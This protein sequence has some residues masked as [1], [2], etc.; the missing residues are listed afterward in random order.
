MRCSFFA[1]KKGLY[2]PSFAKKEVTLDCLMRAIKGHFCS[3]L[4]SNIF[5]NPLF[6]NLPFVKHTAH[7]THLFLLS[8]MEV[9]FGLVLTIVAKGEIPWT[10][11]PASM[12]SYLNAA[13]A[14][15]FFSIYIQRN[16]AVG[17]IV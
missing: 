13:T 6:P 9:P 7:Q 17:S 3:V 14:L 10:V 15:S 4:V 5:C 11:L 12:L 8:S 1:R 16:T 2:A